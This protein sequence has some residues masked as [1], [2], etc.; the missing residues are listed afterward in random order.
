MAI[1]RKPEKSC[2]GSRQWFR[3]A[4]RA[5]AAGPPRRVKGASR[6][7]LTADR[8]QS[9]FRRAWEVSRP[10]LADPVQV[11]TLTH[12][13]VRR[14]CTADS[15]SALSNNPHTVGADPAGLAW[16]AICCT[17][18]HG[19]I[20]GAHSYIPYYN[21]AAVLACAAS[22]RDGGIWYALETLRR[23]D[24]LQRGTDSVIS[25]FVGL[26]S[27]TVECNKSHGKPM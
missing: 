23:C 2:G 24:V 17:V 5:L 10:R 18:W 12:Q 21:R 9:H 19:A 8:C 7:T 6:C 20:T 3:A 14:V 25:A 4:R 1:G 13:Q 16:S 11:E 22:G 27:A 26:A 15:V